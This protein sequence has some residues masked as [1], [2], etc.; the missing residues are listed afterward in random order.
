M[1][2]CGHGR[3]VG[4]TAQ[5]WLLPQLATLVSASFGQ[6]KAE[7]DQTGFLSSLAAELR[8]Q[9]V[10]LPIQAVVGASHAYLR[11]TVTKRDPIATGARDNRDS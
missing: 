1:D 9:W 6:R 4:S 5:T 2:I 8:P 10:S 3:A 11:A 7:R